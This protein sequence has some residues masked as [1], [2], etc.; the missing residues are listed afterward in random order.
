[1]RVRSGLLHFITHLDGFRQRALRI[2]DKNNRRALYNKK[3]G[4]YLC[5]ALHGG[6]Y[7]LGFPEQDE[8]F[9]R[10]FMRT[11][12]CVI[13]SPAYRLSPEATYP[14]A[15]DDCYAALIWLRDHAKE[16]GVR[17]DQLAVGGDS[18]GGGLTAAL[19]IRARDAGE[20]AIAFQMP[21]YPMLDDR[22]GTDTHFDND[23]PVW[24]SRSNRSAWA[25][26]LGALHGQSNI[27]PTAVPACLNDFSGLPPAF[28]YIGSI[29]PFRDETVSY[30]ENLRAAG[31]PV[32]YKVHEGCYHAFDIMCPRS[33]PAREATSALLDFFRQACERYYAH[34]PGGSETE[35]PHS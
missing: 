18:A 15:L 7:A 14:A 22:T 9:I 29:E 4:T 2:Y 24:N 21:L 33:E 3:R 35:K 30:M 11:V 34:Q 31:V 16:Y 19:T 13:V 28:T 17:D 1:M 6:G 23:A 8:S 25:L 32:E 27:P 26:Y 20:V 5:K 12:P 10:N